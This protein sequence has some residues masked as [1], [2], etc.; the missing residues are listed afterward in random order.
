MNRRTAKLIFWVVVGSALMFLRLFQ[1]QVLEHEV[2]AHEADRLV[3]SGTVLP[4]RRGA[5]VD[6]GGRVLAR[7]REAY[8]LVVSYREFRRG[9]P[10]GQVA[11]AR[12]ALEMRPVS[13]RETLDNLEAWAL[14]LTT[15]SLEG[16]EAF[17]QGAPLELDSLV[18]PATRDRRSDLRAQRAS[19]LRFY[20]GAL[21]D[22]S[23][24]EWQE[25][26]RARDS[27]KAGENFAQLVAE[28]RGLDG[29]W[30]LRERLEYDLGESIAHLRMLAE[31][32]ELG[33]VSGDP[34]IDLVDMLERRRRTVE[35]SSANRLFAEAT[36]FSPGRVDPRLLLE[37][38]D[39][40]WIG[41]LLRWDEQ[42]L[43]EWTTSTRESWRRDWC[44]NRALPLLLAEARHGGAGP[45]RVVSLLASLFTPP[46][47]LKQALDGTPVPWREVDRLEVFSRL[48][49]MF[50]AKLPETYVPAE[51]RVLPFQSPALRTRS[52]P[53]S[54]RWQLTEEVLGLNSDELASVGRWKPGERPTLWSKH[55]ASRRWS[56]RE[57]TT[58]LAAEVIGAWDGFF[59]WRLA[60]VLEAMLASA[61][62]E[63]LTA[64]GAL[65]FAEDSLDRASERAYFILK[66]YGSREILI[67]DRPDYEV[68]YLLTRHGDRYPGFR[69]KDARERLRV[70]LEGEVATPAD[71][72]LGQ[73]SLLDADLVQ[74]QR[75]EAERLAQL[76]RLPDRTPREE[77]E[78]AQLL[79]EVAMADELRGASGIESYF[80][81]ELRGR[82]GYRET[83]GL[84]DLERNEH[85]EQVRPVVHGRDVKLTID[86]ELQR[87]A[88][89]V[90]ENAQLPPTEEL[91]D[92]EWFREPVGAIVM[93]SVEGDIL[94][95]AS[96]P[97]A[98]SDVRDDVRAERQEPV[99]RTLRR[100][101]FQPPGSVFKPFVAAWALD[102]LGLDPAF[103]VA[104]LPTAED[105]WANY[106]GVRCWVRT[107]HG[108]EVDLEEAIRGSCNAYFAALGES[109]SDDDLRTMAHAFG[110][111][112]STGIH[113]FP[114]RVGLREDPSPK[115]FE[116]RLRDSERR[117]A[118]NGLA[119]VE[120]T[121]MQV[122]RAM[123]G[124]ATGRLPAVRIV[125]SIGGTEVRPTNPEVLE[126]SAEHLDTVR[127]HMLAVTNNPRGTGY[128]ALNRRLLGFDVA[129]KT[130]S[131]DLES[132]PDGEEAR[133]WK[134]TWVG[135]YFPPEDP[136]IVFVVFL[137]RTKYTASH[138]A[139][140]VTREF[141]THPDTVGWMQ[142]WREQRGAER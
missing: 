135:G 75:P 106:G 98:F 116:G 56:S 49:G 113:P 31:R 79:G 70:R 128:A 52:L 72:F 91:R 55:V 12:S 5:I 58:E 131:A 41:R 42:R 45:D 115:L 139:V 13:L 125:H 105:R 76:M 7:D 96:V 124:L 80:D 93:L 61:D 71:M 133:V 28:W 83:L 16:I 26:R 129:A 37:C 74:A 87:T 111:G 88:E 20:I 19:D 66:D 8:H 30:S 84:G 4:Y 120:A 33:D 90:L 57:V 53:A 95:A 77:E 92:D 119:V 110:F 107:G 112:R 3:H 109:F 134:H 132:R 126:L 38:F 108:P 137:N 15:L 81:P 117:R 104:C 50:E 121:P 43:V 10:L 101:S 141:L 18:L 63:E 60:E 14:E 103:T 59:Q 99:D 114:G 138:T 6:S 118:A 40:N 73:V 86:G 130:G 89:W 142:R 29:E 136:Q 32:L 82:N 9:H 21:L 51:D 2:W 34:L 1:L 69:P 48:D 127:R 11:H 35:D 23:K 78:F 123:A 27:E 122:A 97:N 102:H 36:G 64:T 22:L 54:K 94:A 68:V 39:T 140:H 25:L 24:F 67:E 62:P 44:V 100:H 85:W 17:A 47:L 46:D 65:R